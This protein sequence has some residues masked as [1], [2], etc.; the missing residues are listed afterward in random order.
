MTKT[1]ASLVV[2]LLISA[3]SGS[4][5]EIR[6]VP[7][8]QSKT[9]SPFDDVYRAGKAHLMADRVGLALVM[10]QRALAIDPLSVAAL[11][12]VGTAYDELHR[13]DVAGRYYAKA[14]AIEP[15]STDTLNNMAVSA[16][17]AGEQEKARSLI[18]R[19]LALD[20]KNDAIRRNAAIASGTSTVVLPVAVADRDRPRLERTGVSEIML[21]IPH[22]I[23]GQGTLGDLRT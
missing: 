1:I 15:N 12:A 17:I 19:A 11:N 4:M 2:A 18:S 5:P 10:F 20:P 16:A 7:A 6:P 21:T 13:P 3:C 8:Q 14:L 9:T 23:R 22:R